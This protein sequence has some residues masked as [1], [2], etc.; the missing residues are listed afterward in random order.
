MHALWTVDM[1]VVVAMK[2]KSLGGRPINPPPAAWRPELTGPQREVV[3]TF[4]AGVNPDGSSRN[5]AQHKCARTRINR[6]L[7]SSASDGCVASNTTP[8]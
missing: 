2:D 3:W 1:G 4:A 8:S 5:A 6:T 7:K